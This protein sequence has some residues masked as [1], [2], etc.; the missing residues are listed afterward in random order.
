MK[1]LALIFAF[2]FV[3]GIALIVAGGVIVSKDSVN[4]GDIYELF[5]NSLPF[6]QD[7]AVFERAESIDLSGMPNVTDL[8][9]VSYPLNEFNTVKIIADRCTLNIEP[10]KT[11]DIVAR[12]DSPD[13]EQDPVFL[14]T[15]V[16]DG[17]LYIKCFIA[18][19]SKLDYKDV[20][21]TVGVPES[22]KGGCCINAA[23]GAVNSC[24]LESSMDI[25][26]NL[27]ECTLKAKDISAKEIVFASSGCTGSVESMKS[28][29]G[30]K[31]TTVSSDLRFNWLSAVYTI[32]TSNSTTIK[33]DNV[34]GS[35]TANL[36]T[37]VADFKYP[38][39]DGNITINAAESQFD[40]VI[41][42]NAPVSF[43]HSAM[44]AKV[45]DS[46]NWTD[47]E[48]KNENSHYVIDMNVDFGIVSLSEK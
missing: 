22:Y 11:D 19:G 4:T 17:C 38:S 21:L 25:E 3:V 36:T 32:F 6:A 7:N 43:R 10:L 31:L 14:Q 2:A 42:K 23:Y 28:V 15:A 26:F 20:T 48:G 34:I 46:V 27:Y 35:L 37:T 9:V 24:S 12:I 18:D 45:N 47:G 30:V 16:K 33:A 5:E 8:R 39:I 13:D 40:L 41:P 29:S 1:R 44:Y